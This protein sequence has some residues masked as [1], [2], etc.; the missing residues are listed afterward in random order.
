MKDLFINSLDGY[1][2]KVKDFL[3]NG[4]NKDITDDQGN[5]LVHMSVKFNHLRVFWLL[6]RK[7]FDIN[8]QND[9][10]DTPLHIAA[11]KGNMEMFQHIYRIDCKYQIKNLE[12]KTALQYL[13]EKQKESFKDFKDRLLGLGK[14]AFK[15]KP[16]V[17]HVFG[18]NY[19]EK[20]GVLK[21]R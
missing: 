21:Y 10:G 6:R 11:K 4:G 13:S 14:Y 1:L 2:E 19:S 5:N 12:G 20:S 18:N 3:E 17:P 16:E 8:K 7:G 15:P 9:I